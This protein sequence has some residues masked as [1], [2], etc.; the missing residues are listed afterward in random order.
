MISIHQIPASAISTTPNS[1]PAAR[2]PT[3]ARLTAAG[4]AAPEPASRKGPTRSS[5]VPRTPSEYSLASL[6]PICRHSA[7]GS[8][9]RARGTT[10]AQS[11]PAV[12][13]CSSQ[14]AAPVP[15]ATGATAAG[16][17]RGREPC[18]HWDAVAMLLLGDGA[19]GNRPTN[20]PVKDT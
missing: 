4:G 13:C 7:T 2:E 5:S 20:G 16:Q 11:G 8:A 1:A 12:A 9:S 3:A 10:T 15:A 6:P 18:T 14:A 19:G 17:V